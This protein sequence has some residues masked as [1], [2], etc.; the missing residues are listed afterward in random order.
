MERQFIGVSL[1]GMD[2]IDSIALNHLV[3]WLSQSPCVMFQMT[4]KTYKSEMSVC[5]NK[6]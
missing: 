1:Y 2:S 4:K 3:L 5:T 6:I